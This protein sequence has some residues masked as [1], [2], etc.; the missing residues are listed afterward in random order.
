MQDSSRDKVW[1]ELDTIARGC[2]GPGIS[3]YV[4]GG[5]GVLRMAVLFEQVL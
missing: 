2:D 4:G 1:C 5:I 3:W